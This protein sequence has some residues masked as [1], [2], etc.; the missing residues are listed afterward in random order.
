M[1]R[2][3]TNSDDNSFR[4]LLVTAVVIVKIE[5]YEVRANLRVVFPSCH[6]TI[7][8]IYTS[9]VMAQ[10]EILP[11][12]H[13]PPHTRNHTGKQ[14]YV[15]SSAG[16]TQEITPVSEEVTFELYSRINDGELDN[17]C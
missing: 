14:I 16:I 1:K 10:G 4:L 11:S 17:V 9:F 5:L 12:H 8:K 3:I 2:K 13:T 6:H 7:V 15:T